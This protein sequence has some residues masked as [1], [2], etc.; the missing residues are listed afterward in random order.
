MSPALF[1]AQCS[2]WL[3]LRRGRGGSRRCFAHSLEIT[4]HERLERDGNL[5]TADLGAGLRVLD[6]AVRVLGAELLLGV[7][8]LDGGLATDGLR[9]LADDLADLAHG[10]E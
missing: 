2:A 8:D 10:G 9:A 6:S 7:L 5:V 4:F 1:R 3:L